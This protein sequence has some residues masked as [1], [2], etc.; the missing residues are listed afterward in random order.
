MLVPILQAIDRRGTK[1]EVTGNGGKATE[2]AAVPFSPP[3]TGAFVQTGD[4]KDIKAV[5]SRA[6]RCTVAATQ[7]L[8]AKLFP[9]PISDSISMT[10][11]KLSGA[12]PFVNDSERTFQKSL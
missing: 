10:A 3:L 1:I 9:E 6:Y 8:L 7:T 4:I 11:L 2:L 5:T 12:N